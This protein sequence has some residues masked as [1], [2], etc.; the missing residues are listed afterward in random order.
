MMADATTTFFDTLAERGHEPLLRSTSGTLRFDLRDGNRLERWHVN[1]SKGDVAVSRRNAKADAVV[2]VDKVLFD[3]I[4]AGSVNP[5]A[6]FLRGVVGA[7]GDLKLVIM[8]NRLFPGPP[9]SRKAPA[10]GWAGRKK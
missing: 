2:R 8:F 6:A 9:R 5:M 4:A 10:A 3:R 7:E 1:V